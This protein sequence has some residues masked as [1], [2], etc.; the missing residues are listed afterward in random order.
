MRAI[1]T[2]PGVMDQSAYTIMQLMTTQIASMHVITL[3]P[4]SASDHEEKCPRYTRKLV[5]LTEEQER[6]PPTLPPIT[7]RKACTTILRRTAAKLLLLPT[8]RRNSIPAPHPEPVHP[9][10]LSTAGI[11]VSV[12][13]SPI[14]LPLPRG[15]A[16]PISTD[17]ISRKRRSRELDP[18]VCPGW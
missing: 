8:S 4:K 11:P 17:H 1:H 7:L 10:T 12:Y 18:A 6:N 9:Q 13:T 2:T 16:P 5:I 15:P 3:E 14:A